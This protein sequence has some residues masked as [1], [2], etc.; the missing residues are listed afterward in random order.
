MLPFGFLVTKV[1]NEKSSLPAA[2]QSDMPIKS[3]HYNFL[4]GQVFKP[5]KV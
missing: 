3:Y 4:A 5:T 1:T 2:L